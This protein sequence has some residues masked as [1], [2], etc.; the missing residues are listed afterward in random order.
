[1]A[2]NNEHNRNKNQP[3]IEEP[4]PFLFYDVDINKMKPSKLKDCI[5][6]HYSNSNS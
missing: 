2:L 1:M 4:A 6:L 3:A 5:S